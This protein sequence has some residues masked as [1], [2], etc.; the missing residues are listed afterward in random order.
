M[1]EKH[2]RDQANKVK[3]CLWNWKIVPKKT[4][5]LFLFYFIF[6]TEVSYCE[7]YCILL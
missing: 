5:M 1:V 3:K 2:F 6:T 7:Y 4:F